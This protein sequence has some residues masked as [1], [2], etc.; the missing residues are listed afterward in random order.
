MVTKEQKTDVP[1]L[2]ALKRKIKELELKNEVLR[3]SVGYSDLKGWKPNPRVEIQYGWVYAWLHPLYQ[4]LN[5]NVGF[6]LTPDIRNKSVNIVTA[7]IAQLVVDGKYGVKIPH[8][9]MDV[10]NNF[11]E[12]QIKYYEL[13][14]DPCDICGED[15]ITHACHIIP[16]SEGGANNI[17]NFVTLCP[18]HHHLFDHH[19]LNEEEWEKLLPI[20]QTKATSSQIYA[21]EVREKL[22]RQFWENPIRKY[23]ESD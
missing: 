21:K 4:F 2:T 10:D 14:Y 1:K 11:Q 19:R 12:R 20:L 3:A 9:P 17:Q 13:N 22:L 8:E 6:E 15:R 7:I 23:P 16:R 18:L 5:S